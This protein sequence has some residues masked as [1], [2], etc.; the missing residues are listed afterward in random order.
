MNEFTSKKLGEVLA[1]STAGI[2][3]INR[4]EKG[5]RE[6][7]NDELDE[8][9][10][11]FKSHSEKLRDISSDNEVTKKKSQKTH[12][13]LMKMA[14]MYIGDEWDDPAEMME[15]FG[16]FEGAAVVHWML[17][18]GFARKIDGLEGLTV[19]AVNFHEGLLIRFSDHI[20][21]YAQKKVN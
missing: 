17:V 5:L 12:N 10:D 13:K 9:L 14:E 11:V 8:I 6:I 21:S 18:K 2:E 3:I 4:G 15:W 20:C 16:F 1:F 7:F 19:D